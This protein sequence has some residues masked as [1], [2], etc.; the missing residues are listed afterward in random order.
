MIKNI[1]TWIDGTHSSPLYIN[2]C[3]GKMSARGMRDYRIKDP[4]IGTSNTAR[5]L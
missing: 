2:H 1:I 4:D 3:E 5:L